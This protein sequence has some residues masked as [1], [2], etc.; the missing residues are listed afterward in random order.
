MTKPVRVERALRILPAVEAVEPLRALLVSTPRADEQSRWSSSG[1]YL[2]VGKHGVH[3]ELLRQR[4]DDLLP[5]LTEH[6]RTLYNAYIGAVAA[7]EA[8]DGAAA[9]ASLAEGGAAEERAR[10]VSQAAAW[11]TVAFRMAAELSERGP[12]IDLLER[13]GRTAYELARFDEAAR[14]H[15][16][17]L[18]LAEA[19][20][21]HAAVV[22]ACIGLGRAAIARDELTGA[23]AWFQRAQRQAESAAAPTA[24]GTI[25]FELGALAWRLGDAGAARERLQRAR[26]VLEPIGADADLARLACML[27]QIESASGNHRAA[28]AAGRE[29]LAWA[30]H[31]A[32][33]AQVTAETCLAVAAFFASAGQLLDAEGELRR[34]ESI[35]IEHNF[36]EL[37]VRVYI[38][39]GDLATTQGD[40]T[41]FVFFEQA[42]ELCHAIAP[43]SSLEGRVYESY[44]NFRLRFGQREEAHAHLERARQIFDAVHDVASLTRLGRELASL[45]A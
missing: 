33:G 4:V 36:S 20:F 24:R 29:A 19:T 15:Q 45:S 38:A 1:P 22:R 17:A 18:V 16:R 31:P 21:D 39:L 44:G 14:Y 5:R 2:T 9:V 43:I 6:L 35:A 25:E 34:A 32:V 3:V 30:L 27:G 26:D 28:I 8:D 23:Q 37:L 11:Y 13:L 41:G 40:E 10:R 42:A 12:E 7:M